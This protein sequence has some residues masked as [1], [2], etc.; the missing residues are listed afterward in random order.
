MDL[1]IV[2][3]KQTAL[4]LFLYINYSVYRYGLIEGLTTPGLL[5]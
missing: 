2:L 1:V 4:A 3:V 5:L